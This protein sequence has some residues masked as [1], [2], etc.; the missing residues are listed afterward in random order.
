MF[1]VDRFV[2]AV[3]SSRA[4]AAA[5]RRP[6]TTWP[7]E[8]SFLSVAVFFCEL[9]IPCRSF[10]SNKSSDNVSWKKKVVGATLIRP[11]MSKCK[12]ITFRL[13]WA[14]HKREA[15]P[16]LGGRA[17]CWEL[18]KKKRVRATAI[19]LRIVNSCR[20]LCRLAHNL[21]ALWAANRTRHT[22]FSRARYNTHIFCSFCS[23]PNAVHCRLHCNK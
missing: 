20:P 16:L 7:G 23:M 5:R 21:R 10:Y 9:T 15:F 22:L 6:Q 11:I 13:A 17:E 8:P 2:V 14:A 3:C 19:R 12:N 4:S 18:E 1:H